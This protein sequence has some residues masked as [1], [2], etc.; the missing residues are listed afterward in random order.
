M[1]VI[2]V[3]TESS[4]ERGFLGADH[5]IEAF[6]GDRADHALHL[7]SLPRRPQRRKHL[8]TVVVLDLLRKVVAKD[9]VA[10]SQ[11]IAWCGVPRERVAELLACP[12]RPRVSRDV[13]V[14]DAA[15]VVSQHQ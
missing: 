11:E 15:A 13:E 1:I 12:L 4:P 7:G 2:G 10:I 14:E 8:L 6:T 5:G 9:S 3:Q